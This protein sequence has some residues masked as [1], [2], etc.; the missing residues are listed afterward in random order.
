[1][2]EVDVSVVMFRD[3][4][5]GYLSW[6]AA[7]PDGFV[8][9]IARALS[10]ADARLHHASCRTLHRAAAGALTHSYV[11]V[12]STSRPELDMWITRNARGPVRTCGTCAASAPERAS[13]TPV[14][15]P[16]RRAP[17]GAAGARQARGDT[18]GRFEWLPHP[19]DVEL[20][21]PVAGVRLWSQT[22]LPFERHRPAELS[23][24]DE[25]RRRVAQLEARPGQVLDAVYAGPRPA[26]MDVENLLLYNIDSGGRS[27]A[28][29]TAHGVRFEHL[30]DHAP[31]SPTG[32]ASACFYE[33]RL[34]PVDGTWRTWT[35]QRPLARFTDI[36]LG[37]FRAHKRLEQV[38]YAI[39]TS[40]TVETSS[41]ART[42]L[43]FAV[44][45]RVTPPTGTRTQARPELVKG[46]LDGVIAGLQTHHDISTLP[47]VAE[48][49]AATL[50]VDARE[51]ES[52][53]TR[54]AASPLGN[55]GRLVFLRGPAVQWNPSDHRCVAAQVLVQEPAGSHWVL[56]GDVVTIA[57]HR[58]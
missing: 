7:H 16:P 19:D 30:A 2:A 41:H 11:K 50:S 57:P 56:S 28:A 52:L 18:A 55:P 44:R 5:A 46:L 42:P 53:L 32:W 38:W 23:A 25:L 12:C 27:M 15:Q 37:R 36:S 4:D 48:R 20:H 39:R 31:V 13:G 22:Y 24:R 14:R 40:A 34:A 9:N 1:M 26:N 35:E 6:L 3:D 10:V 33:Y 47:L 21:G 51:V 45:L 58:G 54:S 29:A 49:V 8:L 17:I 43:A